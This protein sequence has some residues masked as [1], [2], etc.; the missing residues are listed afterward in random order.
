MRTNPRNV[1]KA[2]QEKRQQENF[3]K[4]LR[5]VPFEF[6]QDVYRHYLI[7]RD[8]PFKPFF[9]Q[10][11]GEIRGDKNEPQQNQ[12]SL[13]PPLEPIILRRSV[14]YL[15]LTLVGIEC[16]FDLTYIGFRFLFMYFPFPQIISSFTSQ[17]IFIMIFVLLNV[18]K[19]IFMIIAAL[20][21]V[22]FT[23]EITGKEIICQYGVL[24]HKEKIFLCAY[25]QEVMY[26]Q[27]L[28][29]KLFNYG[30]IELHNPTLEEI[31]YLEAVPNPKKHTE[32][33]KSSLPMSQEKGFMPI[34]MPE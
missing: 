17:T 29:G 11:K 14:F 34:K 16:F 20:Q 9:I 12:Q 2:P 23:Y 32:I 4:W 18:S 7:R 8:I 22:S 27:S 6:L 33:I 21:W 26:T 10:Q 24:S 1:L 30:T 5:K 19:V 28:I 31:I 3:S 25:T 13:S 15:I